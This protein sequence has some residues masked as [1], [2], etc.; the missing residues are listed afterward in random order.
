MAGFAITK[1]GNIVGVFSNPKNPIRGILNDMIFIAHMMGGNRM[2]C[3]GKFL[4]RGYRNCGFTPVARTTFAEE[5]YPADNPANSTI[6]KEKPD[7]FFLVKDND[8][9]ATY[10]NKVENDIYANDAIEAESVPLIDSEDSYSD[11]LAFQGQ[12]L[13]E[14]RKKS[15][16]N[17][18]T[19]EIADSLRPKEETVTETQ[20]TPVQSSTVEQPVTTKSE[21]DVA[22]NE[23]TEKTNESTNKP[24]KK[25]FLDRISDALGLYETS[26][27]PKE[28][29]QGIEKESTTT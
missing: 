10:L 5:Y 14:T 12:V 27:T 18:S 11:A 13:K 28:Q 15:N 1:D 23:T 9:N 8:N 3:F 25:K 2:D 19:K 29:V 4:L 22:E 20:E 21:P 7:V 24:N 17:K 6:R 26:E 16:A